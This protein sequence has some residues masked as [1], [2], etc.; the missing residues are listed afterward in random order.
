VLSEGF[1]VNEKSTDTI[2]DRTATFRFVA[3]HLNHCATAV[4]H[5]ILGKRIKLH[6]DEIDDSYS[7]LNIIHLIRGMRSGA[8]G[9]FGQEKCLQDFCGKLEER[10]HMKRPRGRRGK[11]LSY[12][13]NN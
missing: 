13:L 11:I 12:V 3:Q 10:E 7:S 8:C 2:W 9:T 4:T 1:Y 6:N 5:T